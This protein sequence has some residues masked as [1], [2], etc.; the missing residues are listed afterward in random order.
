M[1]KIFVTGIHK[2][3]VKLASGE[4]AEYHYAW[5]GGPKFWQS[6]TGIRPGSPEYLE[7]L[8]AIGET[9]PEKTRGLFRSII[10][11]YLKSNDFIDLAQRT[12]DDYKLWI[13]RI[14]AKFGDAPIAAINLPKIR[15]VALAWRDQWTGKQSQY[16]FSVLKLLV[17][18][19]YD[20]GLLDYHHLRGGGTR[21]STNRAEIIWTMAD[22]TAFHQIAPLHVSRA[23]T[24]AVETG[25]RPGDLV[26][27]SRRHIEPTPMGRRILIRTKKRG[28][29]ASIPVMPE[30][31]HVIAD[32]PKDDLLILRTSKGK[33]WTPGG[34]SQMVKKFAIKA[35]LDNR[36][37]LYDARGTAATRLLV[38][39]VK[40]TE[41]AI[42]MG[43]SV[44]STYR[45]IETYAALDPG[46]TDSVLEQLHKA[47]TGTGL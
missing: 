12:R 47:R 10:C 44:Q 7:A 16:A 43:W 17:S 4:T 25:L 45:M 20:R 19:A 31:A 23:L 37:R 30:M 39:G 3:R 42:V 24:A 22:L 28:R 5:R 46:I 13:K 38:A 36:L 40:L 26:T 9:P 1:P 2:V 11:Q 18:W 29:L 15:P 41:I 14:D 35:G 32:T 34:L 8:K 27:L 6:R 21:Y 33:Q